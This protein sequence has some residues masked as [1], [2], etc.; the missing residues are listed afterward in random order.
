MTSS[1]FSDGVVI[2][3]SS[4][5][6]TDRSARSAAV[7]HRPSWLS[8]PPCTRSR[9]REPFDASLF[10]VPD[11]APRTVAGAARASCGRVGFAGTAPRSQSAAPDERPACTPARSSAPARS[12]TACTEAPLA[13]R[14]G[15]GRAPRVAQPRSS[16]TP[17]GSTSTRT[18][19]THCASN[20][21]TSR[22]RGTTE[23]SEVMLRALAFGVRHPRCTAAKHSLRLPST[24]RSG[25]PG[26]QRFKC[27][28]ATLR[29][30]RRGVASRDA[31]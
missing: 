8:V 10:F 5:S 12:R 6:R 14:S 28:A 30:A 19:A 27:F 17:R 2:R 22:S 25:A 23:G 16:L 15:L 24:R 26:A 4:P 9:D 31:P 11:A 7:L 29:L 21:R 20:P 13:R 18:C 1:R 3:V